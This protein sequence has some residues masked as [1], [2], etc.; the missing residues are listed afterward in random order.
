[1]AVAVAE[2]VPFD[3]A[4]GAVRGAEKR[5]DLAVKDS[6][7]ASLC[8]PLVRSENEA[9]RPHAEYC[10]EGWWRRRNGRKSTRDE[11]VAG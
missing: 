9:E 6:L 3:A 7:P 10:E 11:R 4:F 2:W 8:G 5:S 1:M